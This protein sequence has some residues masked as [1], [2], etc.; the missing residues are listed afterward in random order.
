MHS[1]LHNNFIC[2]APLVNQEKKGGGEEGI[3]E[4]FEGVCAREVC[5]MNKYKTSL[6]L[7]FNLITEVHW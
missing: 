2:I 4:L 1:S 6:G 3:G 7:T 5:C